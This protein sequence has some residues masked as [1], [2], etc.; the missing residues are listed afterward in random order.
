MIPPPDD[1]HPITLGQWAAEHAGAGE[2][3]LARIAGV[4]KTRLNQS[5]LVYLRLD[6]GLHWL[7]NNRRLPLSQGLI[8]SRLERHADQRLLT[9]GVQHEAEVAKSSVAI[10]TLQAIVRNRRE[11]PDGDLRRIM[12]EVAGIRFHAQLNTISVV[13]DLP[14]LYAAS[15]QWQD[16]TL[17]D[18]VAQAPYRLTMLCQL[19]QGVAVF[20]TPGNPAEQRLTVSLRINPQEVNHQRDPD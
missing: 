6:P 15:W 13:E 16:P 2:A 18:Y 11:H 20:P 1:H 4:S 3:E 14:A 12:S 5:R 8:I 9:A 10:P 7:V 19:L 17:A